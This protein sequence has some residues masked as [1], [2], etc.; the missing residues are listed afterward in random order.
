MGAPGVNLTIDNITSDP[1]NPYILEVPSEGEYKIE[2][3]DGNGK[4]QRLFMWADDP[5]SDAI[6]SFPPR[7]FRYDNKKLIKVIQQFFW[8][9]KGRL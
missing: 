1:M 8:L 2:A 6:P 9:E 7:K 3:Y 5:D 4:L